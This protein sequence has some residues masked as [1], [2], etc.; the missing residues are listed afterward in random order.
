MDFENNEIIIFLS[1]NTI[2]VGKTVISVKH[3]TSI[4][5]SECVTIKYL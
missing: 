1:P 4:K 5:L 3:I 2:K